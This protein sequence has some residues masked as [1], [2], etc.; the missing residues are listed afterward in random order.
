MVSHQAILPNVCPFCQWWLI[1]VQLLP[2]CSRRQP[3][4]QDQTEDLARVSPS[5]YNLS[6]MSTCACEK[7]I[8]LAII[9]PKLTVSRGVRLLRVDFQL[10]VS[11]KVWC[12]SSL[13]IQSLQF[14]L[15][16]LSTRFLSL[17]RIF[18]ESSIFC[19]LFKHR[20]YK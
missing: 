16:G 3:P 6:F 15:I 7:S 10:L 4:E 5:L 1:F 20:K 14:V 18:F 17:P 13:S 19:D 11:R 2:S 12:S 9:D 8:G